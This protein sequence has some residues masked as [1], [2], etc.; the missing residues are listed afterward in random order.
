MQYKI[1]LFGDSICFGQLIGN[2]DTWAS[3]LS[4]KIQNLDNGKSTYLLQNAGVNGNTTRQALERL[5]FDVTSHKP[6]YVMVQFGINDCNY[7]ATDNGAPRV[8]EKSFTANIEEIINKLSLSGVKHCFLNTNH[9]IGKKEFNYKNEKIKNKSFKCING[10][11]NN[12]IRDTFLNLKNKSYPISLIDIEI[13]WAKFL[14]KNSEVKLDHLL[15]KDGI[16]LS[17]LGHNLYS[18]IIVPK[19]IKFLKI[20]T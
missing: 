15:L 12:L 6:D 3:K 11:Y 13:E 17:V 2:H 8:S 10:V 16:H 14:K 5:T 20:E 9:P 18:K 7:W 1:Y 19:I 4:K